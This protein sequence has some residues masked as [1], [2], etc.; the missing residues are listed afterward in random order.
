MQVSPAS[1]LLL[2]DNSHVAFTM[3]SIA[4][5]DSVAT[6]RSER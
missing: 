6:G 1:T 3:L 2:R 4:K 5:I